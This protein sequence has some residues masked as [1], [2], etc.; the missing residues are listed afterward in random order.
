MLTFDQVAVG[1]VLDLPV[2]EGNDQRDNRHRA[3]RRSVAFESALVL[4]SNIG[5]LRKARNVAVRPLS[6]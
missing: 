3:G 5:D 4:R 2:A 1:V 6:L